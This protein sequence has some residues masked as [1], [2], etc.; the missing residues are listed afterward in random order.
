MGMCHGFVSWARLLSWSRNYA[1][2]R[3]PRQGR[4]IFIVMIGTIRRRP[5]T[6]YLDR[7]HRHPAIDAFRWSRHCAGAIV[8]PG[9]GLAIPHQGGTIVRRPR[10]TSRPRLAGAVAAAATMALVVGTTAAAPAWAAPTVRTE[11]S[12]TI[13]ADGHPSRDNDNRVGQATPSLRPAVAGR[14]PSANVRWNALGTPYSIGPANDSRP[15]WPPTRPAAARQFLVA[16]PGP[17]RHRR[18]GGG[19]DGPARVAPIG[20]GIGGPA[21]PALRRPARRARRAG[22]RVLGRRTAA[23]SG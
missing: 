8:R 6:T 21:A 16:E 2:R 3:T 17:V 15:A 22:R 18:G 7:N 13:P 20:T 9:G 23:C 10:G 11:P 5:G 12:I 14:A 1:R 4:S 19:R